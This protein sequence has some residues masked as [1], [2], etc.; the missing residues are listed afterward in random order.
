[1]Q[2]RNFIAGLLILHFGFV[3]AVAAAAEFQ[4]VRL[5]NAAKQGERWLASQQTVTGA[6][7]SSKHVAITAMVLAGL[8]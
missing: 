7:E 6:W 3:G 5:Q 8:G 4:S 1:M 2:K